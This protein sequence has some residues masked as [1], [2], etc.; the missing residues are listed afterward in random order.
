MVVMHR[1]RV[2]WNGFIGSPGVS[3]FYSQDASV[4]LPAV[5]ALFLSLQSH[6]P[7]SVNLSF[8]G[9]GDTV[10]SDT[11]VVNGSWLTSGFTT[12]IGSGDGHF[13]AR[14]GYVLSWTTGNLI[15]RRLVRGR[16]FIVPV[17]TGVYDGDGTIIAGA[18]T[19]AQGAVSTMVGKNAIGIWHRPSSTGASDGVYCPVTDGTVHDKVAVNIKRAT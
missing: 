4:G 19:A 2:V 14:T 16:T 7:P 8:P 15:K 10:E 18:L 11:G 13:A 12:L 5:H 3:T 6:L 1:I 9:S 17:S